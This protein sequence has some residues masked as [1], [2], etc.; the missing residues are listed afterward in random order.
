MAGLGASAAA[1]SAGM[2]ATAEA[3][4]AGRAAGGVGAFYNLTLQERRVLQII[5]HGLWL[6]RLLCLCRIKQDLQAKLPGWLLQARQ[7]KLGRRPANRP[8]IERF[9]VFA[10]KV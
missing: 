3:D 8:S 2:N 1:R 9:L 7:R 4:A 5:C 6:V 10:C